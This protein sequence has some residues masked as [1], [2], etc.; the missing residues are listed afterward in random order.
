MVCDK[1]KNLHLLCEILIIFSS[2]KRCNIINDKIKNKNKK[3]QYWDFLFY[4]FN[5]YFF[6]EC[7]EGNS[8]YTTWKTNPLLLVQVMIFIIL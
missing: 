4:K 7:S 5:N 6:F 8:V 3:S 2:Q 1:R